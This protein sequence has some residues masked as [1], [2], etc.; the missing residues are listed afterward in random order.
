MQFRGRT[1]LAI[2]LATA[3]AASAA[4]VAALGLA[5]KAGGLLHGSGLPAGGA[6]NGSKPSAAAVLSSAEMDKLNRAAGLIASRSFYPID[7]DRLIDGAIAG[8]V[9]SLGDP[10]AEYYTED[11]ARQLVDAAD[12]EDTAF[13]G[14]GAKVE[15][16]S[17]GALVVVKVMGG[18]PAE[19]AGLKIGDTLLSVNGDSLEGLTFAEAAAKIRG[20]K[21]TKAKLR[22]KRANE[23]GP[24]ELELVRDRIVAE[25]VSGDLGPDGVGILRIAKF[26]FDT[27]ELVSKE[28]ERMEAGAMK[29]LI[30]DLRDNP[31]GVLSSAESVAGL[32]VPEGRTVVIEEDRQGQRE[33][34]TAEGGIA[35]EG[36]TVGS[37]AAGGMGGMGQSRTYPI[38]VLVNG[39]S[40]S[41]A[42]L[43]AGAL[44]QSA[45]AMLVGSRT[46][47]KGT[48]QI[49]FEDELGDG[50]LMKLTVMKWLLPDGT[51]IEGKGIAP[52]I[53]VPPPL[54]SEEDPDQDPQMLAARQQALS[55]ASGS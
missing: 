27:P 3:F 28:L 15:I 51:W 53:D 26:D 16:A 7:R 42:E 11:E 43:V 39:G 14:I 10:Y 9:N 30:L 48:V 31:G 8:M 6:G 52:D 40:A 13:T 33:T 44:K 17:N 22:V 4:T 20:P 47:G 19:R 1:V 23:E 50:S 55:M 54:E 41:S 2:A 37:T 21:G 35:A 5:G 12:A 38:V 36:T 32:F 49:S 18:T 25:T 24:I 29:A 45:G 46:H 34:K